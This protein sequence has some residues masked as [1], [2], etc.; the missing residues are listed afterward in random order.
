MATHD[1]EVIPSA[2]AD[3]DGTPSE[4]ETSDVEID[5][6]GDGDG[7]GV[8]LS[9]SAEKRSVARRDEPTARRSWKPAAGVV[10]R[11]VAV[12]DLA[13]GLVNTC[14]NIGHMHVCAHI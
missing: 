1:V 3:D 9:V 4:S 7:D 14:V 6:D 13:P 10:V 5:G 8:A 11:R 12:V 2:S